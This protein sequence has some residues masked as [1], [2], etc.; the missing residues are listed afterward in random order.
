MHAATPALTVETGSASMTVVRGMP[1]GSLWLSAALCTVLGSS[2]AAA[3]VSH[4]EQQSAVESGLLPV[5]VFNGVSPGWTIQQRMTRWKVPGVSLAVINDGRIIWAQGYGVL[6]ASG[7]DPVTT[8]TRFQAAS[9]S[10]PVAA[11]AALA[12]V[13]NGQLSLNRP[14]N[15]D[16]RQWTLPASP[17]TASRSL[18]LYDLLSHT[19][20]TTVHGFPGY[21]E[22]DA[23]PTL[24]QILE[25]APPA[26]TAAVVSEATPGERWKYSGGGYEIVQQLIEDVTQQTFAEVVRQQVLLPAGMIA[27]GYATPEAGSFALGHGLDGN[28]IAGGWHNYPEQAAAGLWTTPSDLARFA[29]ALTASLDDS[30]AGLLQADMARTMLTPVMNGYGL[31]PGIGGEGDALAM[32]HGG[33]N[34]GFRAFWIHHPYSGDGVVVM[35]N[36]DGGDRLMM[37]I[38]RAVSATYNWPD[39]KPADATVSDVEPGML[40]DR[41]GTWSAEW[42]GERIQFSAKQEGGRLAL[43][44]FRGTFLFTPTSGET[45]VSDETGATATFGVDTEN[46]PTL[47]VFGLTLRRQEHGSDDS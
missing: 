6:D 12:L 15:E 28:L 46:Q 38:V 16:L 35:T 3:Q 36:G 8:E 17:F 47:T 9:I 7:S 19:G 5:V 31:G 21:A 22:N 14:V 2:P 44:T 30:S 10:K 32:S 34:A 18:T 26:T 39:Y 20:G 23:V 4:A 13:E 43:S 1:M 41:E 40:S 33:S 29:L 42:Q 11:A 25:G 37:E 24:P 45:M 27:S